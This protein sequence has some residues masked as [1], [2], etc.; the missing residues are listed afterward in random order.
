ML[1]LGE[2]HFVSRRVSESDERKISSGKW[3]DSAVL[4]FFWLA[5][6]LIVVIAI[7]VVQRRRHRR[8]I[9]SSIDQNFDN[10]SEEV[11]RSKTENNSLLTHQYD[12]L[13]GK[14][15]NSR[16]KNKNNR[17]YTP[18]SL[19]PCDEDEEFLNNMTSIN[20]ED[21]NFPNQFISDNEEES[22][23]TAPL[24]LKI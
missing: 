13:N 11:N 19:S 21:S 16:I 18:V 9:F 7:V 3:S 23:E 6:F 2:C 22:I 17:S 10:C 4:S 8:A 14:A 1:F 20:K 15:K 5:V 12:I 24:V